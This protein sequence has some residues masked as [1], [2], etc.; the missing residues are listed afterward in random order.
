MC[1]WRLNYLSRIG[2]GIKSNTFDKKPTIFSYFSKTAFIIFS[3]KTQYGIRETD[4]ARAIRI[5]N[6]FVVLNI[7]GLT[8]SR[9]V[10]LVI[11]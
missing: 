4:F 10:G 2:K 5:Q 9:A 7:F 11:T 1:Y 6:S 3:Y 8:L